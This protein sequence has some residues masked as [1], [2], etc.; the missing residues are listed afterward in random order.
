MIFKRYKSLC[1]LPGAG[2]IIASIGVSEGSGAA[3]GS[4][5]KSVELNFVLFILNNVH[6]LKNM[7][8]H[9]HLKNN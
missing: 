7:L 3:S 8:F 4:I 2:G 1:A 9:R 5:P 6:T